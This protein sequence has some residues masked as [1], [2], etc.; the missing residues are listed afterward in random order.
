MQLDDI[1]PSNFSSL[2]D[3]V[4]VVGPEHAHPFHAGASGVEYSST[5]PWI[6]ATRAVGEYHSDI[7]GTDLGGECGVLRASHAAELNLCEHCRSS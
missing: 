1:E 7:A 3:Y 2:A 5:D 4:C 6:D